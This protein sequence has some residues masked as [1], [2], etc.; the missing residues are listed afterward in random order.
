MCSGSL[1]F[2]TYAGMFFWQSSDWMAE[3]QST[4]RSSHMT[5]HE[6]CN[7]HSFGSSVIQWSPPSVVYPAILSCIFSDI[8]AH[9]QLYHVRYVLV[10]Q[11]ACILTCSSAFSVPCFLPSLKHFARH[12][13]V[14]SFLASYLIRQFLWHLNMTFSLTCFALL[15]S[16]LTCYLH[17]IW[18]FIWHSV[19]HFIWI[20]NWPFHCRILTEACSD[21][22]IWYCLWLTFSLVFCLALFCNYSSEIYLAVCATCISDTETS[23]TPESALCEKPN[24]ITQ[25]RHGTMPGQDPDAGALNFA[26]DDA[27]CPSSF[28]PLFSPFSSSSNKKVVL[29]TKEMIQRE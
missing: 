4:Q 14:P 8:L 29:G 24:T 1:W 22:F 2:R 12:S 13:L 20:F 18:R 17:A 3:T 16:Y 6:I 28:P 19:W 23:A 21:S 7:S 26:H 5:W 25:P 11:R 9:V 15:V 27:H 10:C